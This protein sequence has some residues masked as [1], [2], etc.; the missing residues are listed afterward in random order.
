M[1]TVNSTEQAQD[2]LH[3]ESGVTHLRHISQQQW[4]SGIAAWLG[5]TFDGVDMHLYTLVA[6]PFVAQLLGASSTTDSRVGRYSSIIQA[7]FLLGWALGGGFFGRIGDR[8]G[9]AG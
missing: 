7:A 2:G 9:W 4:R 5:W 6:A 8:L 1:E 3:G